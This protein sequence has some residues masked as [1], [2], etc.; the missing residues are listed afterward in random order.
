MTTRGRIIIAMSGGVD[1][2]AAAA[3]LVRQNRDVVGVTMKIWE[4]PAGAREGGCC[5]MDDA[6]D[7]ARVCQ[8]LGIPHY[9]LNAQSTFKTQVVDYFADQYHAGK[10]PNPCVL[11]NQALKFDYL[12]RQGAAFGASRVA[13]GHY[14]RAARFMDY[15]VIAAADD[16]QKDQSYYLFS[17]TPSRLENIEF[18]LAHYDKEQTRALARELGL[19]VA[20]KKESQEICFVPDNDY[21]AFLRGLPGGHAPM[22]GDIVDKAGK[23]LGRHE[24]YAGYTIGQRKGLG[25]AAAEPLYVLGIDPSANQVIVGGRED[26]YS[27]AL[28]ATGANWFIPPEELAGLELSAKIRSRSPAAA[29]E[30]RIGGEGGF[31]LEFAEPQLAIT[32][33]QA[34]A[35]YHGDLLLGGGW[36]E[37]RL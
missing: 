5:S 26:L 33:G 34:V 29:V 32:P 36:I 25:I 14:A 19:A 31:I 15:P 10:T 7:A 8:K 30:L 1:S 12:F 16:R 24:G 4:A 6:M 20:E 2:S 13:T 37:R 9:T 22:A 21:K 28:H 35:V 23:A 17:T 3:I 27:S 18:P 11:C